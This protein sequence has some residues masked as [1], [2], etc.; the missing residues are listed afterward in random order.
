[1][2]GLGFVLAGSRC[3]PRVAEVGCRCAHLGG[4]TCR[5]RFGDGQQRRDGRA[6]CSCG[7]GWLSGDGCGRR[8]AAREFD[9]LGQG[10]LLRLFTSRGG[11]LAAGACGSAA[12]AGRGAR[13]RLLGLDRAAQTVAVGLPTDAVC[14][15]VLDRRRVALHADPELDAQV[16]RFLIGEAELSAELVDADLLRQLALRSSL[17]GRARRCHW[18]PARFPILAHRRRCREPGREIRTQ[19][20]PDPAPSPGRQG[21]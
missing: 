10:P 8:G 17:Q 9:D 1:V 3:R 19:V 4:G 13:R 15:G 12:A 14:L 2:T 18:P 11:V 20:V 6:R 21:W 7:G 5:H 16:E